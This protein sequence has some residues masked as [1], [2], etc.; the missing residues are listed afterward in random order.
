MAQLLGALA[1]LAEDP[2]WV[3]FPV[4]TLRQ[5]IITDNPAPSDLSPSSGVW[6][7]SRMAY[8]HTDAHTNK[9]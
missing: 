2:S 7:P 6:A 5:F 3:Q 9:N 4:Q 8:T 1:A